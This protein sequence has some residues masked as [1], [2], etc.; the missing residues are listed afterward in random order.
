MLQD[1]IGLAKQ[2]FWLARDVSTLQD[3]VREMKKELRDLSTAMKDLAGEQGRMRDNIAHEQERMRDEI[4]HERERNEQERKIFML[5]LENMMLRSGRQLP[6][7]S[8]G[9]P[10]TGDQAA[11][12]KNNG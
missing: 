4:K 8:P 12:E 11:I 3:E 10:A 6:P 5:Q 9:S 1:A 2:L 7:A